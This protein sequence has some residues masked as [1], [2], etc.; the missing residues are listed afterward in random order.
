MRRALT[1]A[2]TLFCFVVEAR[3]EA[4]QSLRLILPPHPSPVVE[5]I[6][7]VLTRQVQQRCGAKV[8]TSGK[9]PLTVELAVEPGIGAE[10]YK[11]AD[12][13][14]GTVRIIGNDD[15][16]LLYGV[17]KFLHTSR[18]DQG[19]FTAGTWRGASAPKKPLRGIYFATHF[20][21]FY[22]DAPIA[23]VQQ[24]VEELGL[25]GYNTLL[26]WY[27]MHLFKDFDDPE[28]VRF[29][30][31]LRAILKTAKDIGLDTAWG[32]VANGGYADS[33][34]KLRADRRGCRALQFECDV[35]PSK[36]G[37]REYILANAARLFDEFADLKPK[38]YVLA[39][40]DNGGCE[41]EQCRPWSTNGY[42]RMSKEM[43]RLARKSLPES[44]V[45]LATMLFT[46]DEW[47]KL[48]KIF[49]N[50]PD[51]FDYVMAEYL[52]DGS[53]P[54]LTIGVLRGLPS[55]GF[56][57]ISMYNSGPWGGFGVQPLP[58]R[59]QEQ[60]NALK[61]L[62][63]GGFPYSEGIY[64]DINK[65][66]YSQFYW[67]DRPAEETLREYAAF[68]YSPEVVDEVLKV[69][70]TLEQNQRIRQWPKKGLPNSVPSSAAKP[71]VD[72]GAEEAYARVQRIDKKLSPQVRKSWRW[73]LLYLRALLD[74][75][76]KA[77]GGS[78]NDRCN[79]AFAELIGIYHAQNADSAVH[80]PLDPAW[81][82]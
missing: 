23:D 44:K 8:V 5:N 60:W 61:Q 6:A 71:Q 35:C 34:A 78:P 46:S 47:R 24:Y 7:R 56:P 4:L 29:R 33:P 16:G 39:P 10:G 73:R 45:I 38:Y 18:Y 48:Q 37:G 62:S 1:V 26:G 49:A 51:C 59:F 22:H 27:D 82:K 28:A 54:L 52:N 9:A 11:V 32:D 58:R 80:P 69:I 41:C 12:G 2:L 31:R 21:N 55:V 19:G 67:G 17:G 13:A 15:R 76:L 77:N 40:Y 64:E 25:W 74:A 3:G 68:E 43:A 36:P 72:P 42:I 14:N 66:V 30:Q 20:H 65:V 75:E 63:A 57:E 81:R 50:G 53:N 70:A 79:E